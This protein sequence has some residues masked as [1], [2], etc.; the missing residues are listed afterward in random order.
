MKI[1]RMKKSVA[2]LLLPSAILSVNARSHEDDDPLLSR[3]MFDQLEIRDTEGPNTDRLEGQAWVGYDKHK[4]WLKSDI[5]RRDGIT[6]SAELQVLASMA[7]APF[8]DLQ[9]GVRHDTKPGSTR[10]WG[11][12]GAQ[13]LAPYFFDIDAAVFVGESGRT[14]ARFKAE[15][16]LLFTQKLI[17]A[18]TIE[19]N[20]YGQNDLETGAGAGLSNVEAGLRLRY[21]IRREFAPYIGVNWNKKFGNTAD[22]ARAKGKTVQ[23]AQWV[24]G[25]RAWF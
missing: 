4:L 1:T 10:S 7:V 20:L 5:E 17:L 19:V 18:P 2:L 6:E 9:S 24:V 13:G 8:W 21:E 23:D 14:A 25:L 12:I 3:V 11:V 16:D 22:F 15:Y